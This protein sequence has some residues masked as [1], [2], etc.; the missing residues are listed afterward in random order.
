MNCGNSEPVA[1]NEPVSLLHHRS[2]MYAIIIYNIKT[3]LLKINVQKCVVKVTIFYTKLQL[4]QRKVL[5]GVHTHQFNIYHSHNKTL[6]MQCTQ[7]LYRCTEDGCSHSY[8]LKNNLLRHLK[9]AHGKY[10]SKG[11]YLC[12]LE[13]CGKKFYQAKLLKQHYFKEHNINIGMHY[14]STHIAASYLTSWHG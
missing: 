2:S 5:N 1:E 13:A 3:F 11:R 12:Q 4:S 10:E 6:S 8:T 14:T 7:E 9:T